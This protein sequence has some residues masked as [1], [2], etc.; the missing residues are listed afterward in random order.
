MA[1]SF[2]EFIAHLAL[3]SYRNKLSNLSINTNEGNFVVI[4]KRLLAKLK[5]NERI[6]CIFICVCCFVAGL[7][8]SIQ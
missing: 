5:R 7:N 4:T 6:N 3:F 2:L 8:I 1:N